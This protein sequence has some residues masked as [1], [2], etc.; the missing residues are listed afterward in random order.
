MN[1]V[2]NLRAT[3]QELVGFA[4]RRGTDLEPPRKEFTFQRGRRWL[5]L[6]RKDELPYSGPANEGAG[7][8][9]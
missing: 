8:L 5:D 3:A 7:T 9:H 4:R 6:W 1:P 2:D